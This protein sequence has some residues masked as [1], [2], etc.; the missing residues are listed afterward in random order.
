MMKMRYEKLNPEDLDQL[1]ALEN[2]Y[3]R[4]IGEMP[5][6]AQQVDRLRAAVERQDIEFFVGKDGG[7]LVAMCSVCVLFSTYL[8][9][10]SGVF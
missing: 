3:K 7:K 1:V 4:S 8:C 9:R 10:P 5:L 6:T 2:T